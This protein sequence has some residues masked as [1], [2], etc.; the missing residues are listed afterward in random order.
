M[1][2]A[3]CITL[4]AFAGTVVW[5]GGGT[6]GSWADAGNWNPGVPLDGDTARIELAAAAVNFDQASWVGD[7]FYL[8]ATGVGASF[9]QLANT[10]TV[11]GFTAGYGSG[12]SASFNLGGGS[13]TSHGNTI[14]GLDGNASAVQT[15]GTLNADALILAE[16]GGNGSYTFQDGV[17]HS[18]TVY[19]G[20]FEGAGGTPL[21]RQ[22]GGSH[23]VTNALLVG[24]DSTRT[25]TYELAGGTLNT[26]GSVI[27]WQDGTGGGTGVFTHTTGTHSTSGDLVLGDNAGTTSGAYTL[28][29][30]GILE[31]AGNEYVGK[32]GQ[33]TF[34]QLAGT[35]KVQIDLYVD[36]GV[37]SKGVFNLHGGSLYVMG[38]AF[39]GN[40]AGSIA[41]FNQDGGTAQFQQGFIVANAQQSTAYVRLSGDPATTTLTSDWTHVGSGGIGEFRQTG[42]THQAN[43][44]VIGAQSM[45]VGSFTLDG[46]GVL[47]VIGGSIVGDSA[48]GTLDGS[49]QVIT[50]GGSFEQ[51][52]GTHNT[53]AL[54]VGNQVGSTGRYLLSDGNLTVGSPTIIGVE[55]SGSFTQNGGT[56]VQ[57]GGYG[58]LIL[59]NIAT[60]VGTYTLNGGLLRMLGSEEYIGEFG[61]GYFY[62]TGGVHQF[63]G[64]MYIG[65]SAGGYGEYHLSGGLLGPVLDAAGNPTGY[66]GIV[67]GE[68]S[69]TGKFFHSGGTVDVDNLT[70]VRQAG[71]S[72]YYEMSEA[73]PGT[74]LLNLNSLSVGENSTG[75]FVHN[76]G[77]ATVTGDLNIGGTILGNGTYRMNNGTLNLTGAGSVLRIG[78]DGQ[79]QFIQQGG[80]TNVTNY[81]VVI[82]E[83]YGSQGS[84]E[85][86]GGDLNAGGVFVGDSG[87]GSFLQIAGTS[88]VGDLKLGV[89]GP[90]TLNPLSEGRYRLEGGDLNSGYVTVGNEGKGHFVQVGGIH[91]I[92]SGMTIGNEA[93]SEGQYGLQGGK[94]DAGGLTI[95]VAQNGKGT[96]N[97]SNAATLIADTVMVGAQGTVSG[98]GTLEVAHLVTSGLVS[99][100]NSPGLLALTGDYEQQSGGILKIE[101]AGLS[102]FDQLVVGGHAWLDGTLD[103]YKLAG[104]TPQV[105][106]MFTILTAAGGLTGG[107]ADVTYSGFGNGVVFDPVNYD[108][109]AGTVSLHIAAVPEPET[110]AML[111]AGLGLVGMAARRRTR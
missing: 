58:A 42:G 98:T 31:V 33:G 74:T 106:D 19:V 14:F 57:H 20:G 65:T 69:A 101:I 32:F 110:W 111:L 75:E 95:V 46:V 24:R 11:N 82:A 36:A 73:V 6:P 68:W 1:L 85:L 86:R 40:N 29:G 17:I 67:L 18:G 77:T 88:N 13:F 12:A 30:T 49:G 72:G 108:Y 105:G 103:V 52:S 10:L 22:E 48:T 55:G 104:Y 3:G 50:W 80:S 45:G 54:S 28:S 23:S 8:K 76:G 83:N 66:G 59:G 9:S 60:G 91:T 92:T 90:K 35:H 38:M 79:G 99:P 15:G 107:F 109:G 5:T 70:L 63:A 53:G 27:G 97:V 43:N 47:K 21:F 16:G 51:L 94:L 96:L 26:A 34:N 87:K 61:K 41:E 56:F 64:A 100:G 7:L 84:Y 102:S 71:S 89:Y 4:P 93:G 44:L 37:A 25:A 39:V 78:V 2:L 62:Q 81:L